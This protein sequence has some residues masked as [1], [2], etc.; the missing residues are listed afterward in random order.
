MRLYAVAALER[1]AAPGEDG[2]FTKDPIMQLMRKLLEV[3]RNKDVRKCIL[4]VMPVVKATTLQVSQFLCNGEEARQHVTLLCSQQLWNSVAR[5][6]GTPERSGIRKRQR[7]MAAN[8]SLTQ[9]RSN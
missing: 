1:L 3:E 6:N 2:L 4:G 7:A 8:C 5:I 9:T